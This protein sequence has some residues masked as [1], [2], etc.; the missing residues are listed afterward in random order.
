MRAKE[1]L[2]TRAGG[3]VWLESTHILNLI[4]YYAGKPIS[5]S[6][7]DTIIKR[8]HNYLKHDIVSS[9]YLIEFNLN[10]DIISI[11]YFFICRQLFI[12][13]HANMSHWFLCN[14]GAPNRRIQ[15]LDSFGPSKARPDLQRTVIT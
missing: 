2:A 7:Y 11:T 6:H 13:I 4:G 15:I 12:P 3:K 8:V 1:H 5:V 14:V 9:A 10:R